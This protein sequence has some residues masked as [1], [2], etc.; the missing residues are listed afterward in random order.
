SPIPFGF[1]SYPGEWLTILQRMRAY[2]Y[3]VLLPG[4]GMPMR[5]KSYLDKLIA[6]I[7]AARTQA[8]ALAADT[9]ITQENVAQHVDFNDLR[10]QSVGAVPW[11]RRWFTLYWTTPTAGSALREA[12][13]A[14]IAQ[15]G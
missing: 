2:D 13:T 3:A 10:T 8:A 4:H 15:G 14:P 9:T 7:V 6:A 12:R 1:D 11:R 5:D